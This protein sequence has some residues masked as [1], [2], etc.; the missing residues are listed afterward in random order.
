M[1]VGEAVGA[2]EIAQAAV[3]SNAGVEKV[4]KTFRCPVIKAPGADPLLFKQIRITRPGRPAIILEVDRAVPV[5]AADNND[6]T[7]FYL[8]S[9]NDYLIYGVKGAHV[10]VAGIE[11]SSRARREANIT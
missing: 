2:G 4:L 8:S 6:L 9:G 10:E 1:V 7:C 3:L 11:Q 5:R